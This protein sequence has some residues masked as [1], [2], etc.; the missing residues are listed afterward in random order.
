MGPLN[1]ITV[2]ELGG[3]GP[4]PMAG[5]MLADMGAEVIRVERSLSLPPFQQRDVSFRGK[6]SI[7][8]DLKSAQGVQVLLRLLD[9]AHVLIDPY[10]PGVLERLGL[11]PDVC[12]ARNTRLIYG[13]I[14]GWGQEGPLASAAGHDINY[15]ALTGALFAVGRAG[16]S[17]VPPLN[18]VG[19]MGGGGMLLAYGIVCALLESRISGKGQVI[20]AAMIDGAAHLMGMVHSL[21]AAGLWDGERRGVNLFDGG[22]HFY[23]TYET[24]DGKHIAIG[25]I[26]PQFYAE[27]VERVG[28]DRSRFEN[29]DDRSRW[30]ELKAE[31]TRLFKTRTRDEWCQLLEGT[32]ACFAPVLSF[33]EA[34]EHPHHRARGTYT[35]VDGFAQPA[36]AP[37]FSRTIA[38]VRHGQRPP[39][40][41]GREVLASAGFSSD[42]IVALHEAQVVQGMAMS[43]V[44]SG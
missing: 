28:A 39:G 5:M 12:L 32:D 38:E 37:R 43:S 33:L 3:I 22:A 36:P 6:K 26:E 24:S 25:A 15:I 27:L 14:T 41:D 4:G 21:H 18:L 9:T 44:H 20:D 29:P 1:G 17:P 13:R 34:P 19:D 42:E 7:V 11:G 10:R 31:L 8:V 30:P 23:D 2:I 16:E 35:T 40:A